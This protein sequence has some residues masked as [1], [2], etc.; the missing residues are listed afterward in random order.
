MKSLIIEKD[1]LIDNIN[2]I[3]NH[4]NSTIIATLKNNGYG[5]GLDEYPKILLENGID[6]FA[7][8]TVEEAIT[9][10]KNGFLNKILLL[11]STG[12]SEDIELLLENNII[13]T[14]G[15]LN[16][17]QNV[18]SIAE[19]K[20]MTANVHIKI[21]TGFGRFGFLPEDIDTL[22]DNIKLCSNVKIHGIYSHFSM[23]FNKKPKYTKKQFELFK[24]C[25]ELI[26][27]KGINTG[28]SHICNSSAFLKFPDMH[29]DAVRVGSAFLG[30][31]LTPNNLKLNK[32]GYLKA[33]IEEI[34]NLPASHFIGYSNTYKT[35]TPCKI[36]VIPTGYLDGIYMKKATD[37]FRF[38]DV[39]RD[40]YG[41]VKGFHSKLYV[42]VHN[43]KA[44]ILGKIGTN[45]IT[46][47]ITNVPCDINDE[48]EINI[49]PMMTDKNIKREFV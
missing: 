27:A 47:D 15:S 6:F 19:S 1:K 11:H 18:N 10:R 40:V 21:D 24:M 45:N 39:L 34:K 3:K 38:N 20:N 7:V 5:L 16:T 23:S 22:V 41:V 12:I 25:V 35:K 36:A 48:V 28:I 17:L 26:N 42:T 13:L 9:L 14:I 31:I 46:I 29:L 2:K 49:N 32:I 33:N 43:K 44:P 8:S 37:C 30:R 4:T